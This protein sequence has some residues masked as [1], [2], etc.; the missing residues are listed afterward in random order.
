MNFY[1]QTILFVL[2]WEKHLKAKNKIKM[3][4]R[5]MSRLQNDRRLV[6]G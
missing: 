3:A 5:A 6:V 4:Y 1:P 2:K